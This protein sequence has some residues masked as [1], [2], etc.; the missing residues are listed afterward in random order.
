MVMSWQYG[1]SI[2]AKQQK[3]SF[4]VRLLT[5]NAAS[6]NR[7]ADFNK[8]RSDVLAVQIT[9]LNFE[10]N[11]RIETVSHI[12]NP[13]VQ[14][15]YNKFV[16]NLVYHPPIFDT[17]SVNNNR[18]LRIANGEFVCNSYK[19]S[20]AYRYAPSGATVISTVCAVGIPPYNND[21]S[22]IISF[23]LSEEPT[24]EQRSILF[25]FAR[26]ISIQIYNDSKK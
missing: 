2:F 6:M 17:D 24:A 7:I 25:S 5:V 3:E 20:V 22:G 9:T 26:D 21:I 10:R 15:L 16:N 8:K 19:D 11:I 13:I 14:E 1:T 23:Y 4:G 18:M 12:D